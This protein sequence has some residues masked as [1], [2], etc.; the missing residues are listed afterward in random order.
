MR[1]HRWVPSSAVLHS[2]L[3]PQQVFPQRLFG[4]PFFVNPHGAGVVVVVGDSVVVPPVQA[5][6]M[7][8]E[9]SFWHVSHSPPPLP[10]LLLLVPAEQA[11][12][13]V[14]QPLK[15]VLPQIDEPA[16]H[17][18][19]PTPQTN[20]PSTLVF[21]LLTGAPEPF[22]MHWSLAPKPEL[23][24]QHPVTQ[25]RAEQTQRP[26]MG[27]PRVPAGQVRQTVQ[28]TTER[29]V[30]EE[31]ARIQTEQ[32]GKRRIGSIYERQTDIPAD[33]VESIPVAIRAYAAIR[34]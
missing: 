27:S 24:I 2:C 21:T 15:S 13:A 33:G 11:P 3:R 29:L 25:L 14:Q 12:F 22:W 16:S 34:Q 23:S 7:P 5:W 30:S 1:L 26:V 6:S 10:Q 17:D 9:A 20:C 28:D 32:L 4:L 8:H 19:P 31:I 18:T